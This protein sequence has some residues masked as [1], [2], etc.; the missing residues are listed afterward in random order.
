MY[1]SVVCIL[2]LCIINVVVITAQPVNDIVCLTQNKTASF[3]CVVDGGGAGISSAGWHI[4]V[5][6]V[7]ILVVG[8]E[9]HTI[10]PIRDGDIITDTLT[11][12]NVSMNDNGALYRCQPFSNVISMSATLIVLG[13]VAV[14]LS[15]VFK[16]MDANVKSGLMIISDKYPPHLRLVAK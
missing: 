5:G 6:G 13:E 8:R 16:T 4:L 1:E 14:C 15:C 2:Y 10:N 11:V 7:Y 12:T 9:R 3:T